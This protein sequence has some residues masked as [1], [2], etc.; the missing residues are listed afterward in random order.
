MQV[1][2]DNKG[3]AT[4]SHLCGNSLY[5]AKIIVHTGNYSERYGAG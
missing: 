4:N 3:S 1:E 2:H 5:L